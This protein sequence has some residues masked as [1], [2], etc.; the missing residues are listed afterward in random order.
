MER[1]NPGAILRRWVE[2]YGPLSTGHQQQFFDRTEVAQLAKLPRRDVEEALLVGPRLVY[3]L[4]RARELQEQRT[5]PARISPAPQTQVRQPRPPQKRPLICVTCQRQ[6][7]AAL[8]DTTT[9][10]RCGTGNGIR[11]ACR[12]CGNVNDSRTAD[13][14]LTCLEARATATSEAGPGAQG[15]PGVTARSPDRRRRAWTGQLP[16]RPE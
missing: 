1:L 15:P 5:K 6:F 4:R 7:V 10:R 12:S 8:D 2:R 14:C 13:R 9:C 11:L 16:D 3:I